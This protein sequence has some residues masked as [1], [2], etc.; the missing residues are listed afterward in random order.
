VE[1]C[2]GK[3]WGPNSVST[4]ESKSL[5]KKSRAE[6][7]LSASARST[8]PTTDLAEERANDVSPN[9]SARGR[10]TTE[11]C[12]IRMVKRS[13][14]ELPGLRKKLNARAQIRTWS[15]RERGREE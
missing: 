12:D 4:G 14:K 8:S 11:K 1:G 2:S 15:K 13:P 7:R 9:M 6:R 5:V 3:Q 10:S